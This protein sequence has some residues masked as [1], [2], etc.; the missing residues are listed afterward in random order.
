MLLDGTMLLRAQSGR[1]TKSTHQH[2]LYI[3][4]GCP[5]VLSFVRTLLL[6]RGYIKLQNR[7]S[8]HSIGQFSKEYERDEVIG[9]PPLKT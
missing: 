7:K 3:E 9:R 2:S 4:T 6:K 1:C 5:I 8:Q